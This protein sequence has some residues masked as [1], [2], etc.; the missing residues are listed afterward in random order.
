MIMQKHLQDSSNFQLFGNIF[1][2]NIQKY[3]EF[4]TF[5]KLYIDVNKDFV[6]K[7]SSLQNNHFS[8]LNYITLNNNDNNNYDNNIDVFLSSFTNYFVLFVKEQITSIEQI[9]TNLKQI[10]KQSNGYIEEQ[11]ELI[12][13]IRNDFNNN[14]SEL[15]DSYKHFDK[16]NLDF[17]HEVE[18][19]EKHLIKYQKFKKK[20]KL[21]NN[22]IYPF[23]SEE[24]VINQ[25]YSE[26][27]E[28]FKLLNKDTNINFSHKVQSKNERYLESINNHIQSIQ[29]KEKKFKNVF[30]H[31]KQFEQSFHEQSTNKL[32]TSLQI[33]KDV[34]NHFFS[35]ICKSLIFVNNSLKFLLAFVDSCKSFFTQSDYGDKSN[36][37][38]TRQFHPTELKANNNNSLEAYKLITIEKFKTEASKQPVEGNN[39]SFI[40]NMYIIGNLPIEC[41]RETKEKSKSSSKTFFTFEDM[42]FI[43]KTVYSVLTDK[44]NDDYY[45]IILEEKKILLN[46]IC[47]KILQ[48]K[49]NLTIPNDILPIVS[50]YLKEQNLRHFFLQKLNDLRSNGIFKFSK[51]TYG[52]VGK[53]LNEILSILNTSDMND[54][55]SV[56]SV[57]I[58]S[59]TFYIIN[60]VNDN[61]NKVYLQKE[62]Q[63]HPLFKSTKFWKEF[64][65]H[66]IEEEI[67]TSKLGNKGKATTNNCKIDNIVFAQ[68]VPLSDNMVEFGVPLNQIKEIIGPL[69]DKYSIQQ[70][71]KDMIYSI[72][73]SKESENN[74]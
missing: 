45:N 73:D 41:M 27:S 12:Y 19:L 25:S 23:H 58:L 62:I 20:N 44:P 15:T 57:I 18:S 33:N 39:K 49:E 70:V 1:D 40:N 50:M 8:Q 31:L 14:V 52:L 65:E 37:F 48:N 36:E 17:Q 29:T 72:L 64:I 6:K 34:M 28:L 26:I 47:N 51:T 3:K 56:K 10:V 13:H 2:K 69:I 11:I 66:S 53:Y 55:Y 21:P 38:I 32:N 60:N 5:L 42:H 59:Q 74:K 43:I 61:N 16:I 63:V 30:Q 7:L 71:Q 67:G 24:E 22:N 4:I 9:I 35:D 54:F 46:Y 68:L